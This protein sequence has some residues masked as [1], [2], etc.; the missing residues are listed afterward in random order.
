MIWLLVKRDFFMIDI[1]LRESP[2]LRAAD[3]WWE[4]HEYDGRLFAASG[5]LSGYRGIDRQVARWC[6]EYE[7]EESL[8]VHLNT[9]KTAGFIIDSSQA[10]PNGRAPRWPADIAV[11]ALKAHCVF[12]F[13][14]VS[15]SVHEAIARAI[16]LSCRTFDAIGNLFHCT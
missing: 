14:K 3:L 4:Y 10:F 16:M 7:N 12:F 8:R 2:L 13:F 1:L 6:F 5:V 9:K 15:S 11:V